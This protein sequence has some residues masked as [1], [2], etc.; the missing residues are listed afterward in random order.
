M[1]ISK[2]S[3]VEQ[4]SSK[5]KRKI[6]GFLFSNQN[7]VSERE[8]A[9]ILGVSNVA[10]NK[11]MKQL[12]E[13]NIVKANTGGTAFVWQVNEKSF[14]YPYVKA[15][16][17]AER[18]NPLEYVKKTIKEEL[19]NK[20]K[21]SATENWE[22]NRG[23]PMITGAYI[24]GSV[25]D[26]TATPESD[27]DVLI[28]L[29]FDHKNEILKKELSNRVGI[30]ILEETGNKISFHVYSIKSLQKNEP[31]WLQHAINNGIRV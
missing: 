16:V 30:K 15:F 17:E 8:L 6:L 20:N 5:L 23:K 21:G 9:R 31:Q 26:K 22:N 27:I 19:E 2:E 28:L 13:F 3:I 1:R 11:A 24:F 29:E 7:P 18:M 25:V 10:V 12:L 4:F 14:T